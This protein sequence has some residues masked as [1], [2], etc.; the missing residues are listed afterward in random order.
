MG[1][2]HAD[3]C[4]LF[5][6]DFNISGEQT[7]SHEP[8]NAGGGESGAKEWE[9]DGWGTFEPLEE[10]VPSSGADFFDTLGQSSSKKP[11]R[12]E[13]LFERLGV[14]VAGGGGAKKTSP[15]P[16]SSSLFGDLSGAGGRGGGGEGDWG[17]WGSDFSSEK[18]YIY[19]LSVCR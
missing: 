18:V 16:V 12:E 5:I 2:D 1:F 19:I 3:K 14:G 17:D 9:D 8:V 13:D 4:V 7:I 15:P 10:E 11:G 6:Q